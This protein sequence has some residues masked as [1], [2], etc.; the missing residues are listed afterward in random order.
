MNAGRGEDDLL[1]VRDRR[2]PGQK[3]LCRVRE[4]VVGSLFELQFRQRAGCE[5]LR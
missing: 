4:L 1:K 5:V 3:I 2:N